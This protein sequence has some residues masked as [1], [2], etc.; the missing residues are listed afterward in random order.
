M[1]CC[2][3]RAINPALEKTVA[4]RNIF[5]RVSDLSLIKISDM[6]MFTAKDKIAAPNVVKSEIKRSGLN[7]LANEFIITQGVTMYNTKS[8]NCFI[9]V[10]FKNLILLQIK[11]TATNTNNMKTCVDTIMILSIIIFLLFVFFK[12]STKTSGSISPEIDIDSIILQNNRK[13][14]KCVF[15]CYIKDFLLEL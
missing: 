3:G 12:K 15:Q 13:K 5:F 2:R 14:L 7:S 1:A 11:P 6:M 10:K 9:V 4:Y 8:V